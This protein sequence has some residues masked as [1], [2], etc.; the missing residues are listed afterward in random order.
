MVVNVKLIK[1][2]IKSLMYV[3]FYKST[4]ESKLPIYNQ[5]SHS[6]EKNPI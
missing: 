6:N 5:K 2:F 4:N 3:N 1:L